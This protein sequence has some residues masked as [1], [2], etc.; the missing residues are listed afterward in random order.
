M[1]SVMGQG[2]AMGRGGG[3]GCLSVAGEGVLSMILGLCAALLVDP[4]TLGK[5]ALFSPGFVYGC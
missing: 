2:N 5:E 1:V 4:S 3:G